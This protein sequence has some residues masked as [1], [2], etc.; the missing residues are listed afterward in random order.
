MEAFT[1]YRRTGMPA[2]LPGPIVPLGPQPRRFPLPPAELN[3]NANAPN[4]PPLVGDRIFWD[5]KQ[6][7]PK[8]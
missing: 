6:M 5:T 2:N 3:S 1:D 4:P 7:T 8:N